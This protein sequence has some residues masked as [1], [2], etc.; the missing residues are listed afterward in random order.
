VVGAILAQEIS[1]VDSSLGE[2]AAPQ[3]ARLFSGILDAGARDGAAA[4]GDGSERTLLQLRPTEEELANPTECAA[5]AVEL[6]ISLAADSLPAGQATSIPLTVRNA[7]EV[8]CLLEV[9][10]AGVEVR[11]TSGN[12]PVWSS[13]HCGAS[14]PE[15]RR[16]LLD[17][18]ASDTTVV[19]WSGAR[20]AEGCPGEQP[21]TTP[22]TYR[23]HAAVAAAGGPV[24]H[25][26]VF[27]MH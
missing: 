14:L 10:H 9:G 27:G 8:P 18:G 1:F 16:I 25:E 22:G 3:Q 4:A 20:S 23:V 11:V 24:T 21:A 17:V 26:R 15:D 5:K 19:T 13:T 7:G 6:E 2:D 12:D